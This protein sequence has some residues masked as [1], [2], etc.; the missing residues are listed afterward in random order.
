MPALVGEAHT[1]SSLRRNFDPQLKSSRSLTTSYRCWHHQGS[2]GAE[3]GAGCPSGSEGQR[4]RRVSSSVPTHH[5]KIHP[6]PRV[7][8]PP[9]LAPPLG[10]LVTNDAGAG[11]DDTDEAFWAGPG[12]GRSKGR[13]FTSETKQW[14]LGKKPQLLE[15]GGGGE[16]RVGARWGAGERE[17]HLSSGADTGGCGQGRALCRCP[18]RGAGV[19]E[20]GERGA[21]GRAPGNPVWRTSRGGPFL[22]LRARRA[23][24]LKR[25]S[26]SQPWSGS[27]GFPKTSQGAGALG[28][29]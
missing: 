13:D 21:V 27:A 19:L 11:S 24:R 2:E 12:P 5:R 7:H 4:E 14:L 9:P 20:N 25:D 16:E 6:L 18:G 8:A 26:P 3:R 23:I 29:D 1:G 17:T 28:G 10:G 22:G 15:A